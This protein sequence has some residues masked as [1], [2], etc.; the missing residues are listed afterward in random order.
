MPVYKVK[1]GSDSEAKEFM[2]SAPNRGRAERAAKDRIC[3]VIESEV[4]TA[5]QVFELPNDIERIA[6]YSVSDEQEAM[7]LGEDE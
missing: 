3:R 5:A 6:V 7:H 4:M 1:I 2:V